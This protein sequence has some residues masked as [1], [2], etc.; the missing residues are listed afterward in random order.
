MKH[1]PRGR[2]SDRDADDD[3][4]LE[5]L[6]LDPASPSAD[7]AG[8]PSFEQIQAAQAEALPDDEVR[9]VLDHLES[10]QACRA[11]ADAA[12]EWEG[13]E[14]S[15]EARDTIRR[16]IAAAVP[17]A[18]RLVPAWFLPLAAALAIALTTPFLL[19]DRVPPS[20]PDPGRSPTPAAAFVLPLEKLERRSAPA[21]PVR[22]A[23]PFDTAL[24]E[25]LGAYEKDDLGEAVERLARLARAHP[26]AASPRLYLGVAELLRG[27]P[28]AA[29][30]A[31]VEA[32]PLA[33]A[34][35]TPHVLWYLAI[36]EERVGARAAAAGLLT[37]LCGQA[38]EYHDR[39]CAALAGPPF[40]P[41]AA[42]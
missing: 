33:R 37:E 25:A 28:E 9:A 11:L 36:A 31:L 16:R 27:R 6:G 1:P 32:R 35:W 40:A 10:C 5:M 3:A 30:A 42:R 26:E 4:I 39:A 12:R 20:L 8:C 18:R 23:D 17:P 24:A 41:A 13:P 14:L 19:R 38:G 34:F 29:R 7:A 22:A 21:L 15:G 2:A